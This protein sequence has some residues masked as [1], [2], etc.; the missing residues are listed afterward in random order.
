VVVVPGRG[1]F[2]HVNHPGHGSLGKPWEQGVAKA[3]VSGPTV[4]RDVIR[5]A[6]SG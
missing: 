6:M 2:A 4:F 3:K 1:V 5:K